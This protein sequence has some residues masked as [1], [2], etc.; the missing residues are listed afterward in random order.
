MHNNL[1]ETILHCARKELQDRKRSRELD[2]KLHQLRL[3]ARMFS[4]ELSTGKPRMR[5]F[6][7]SFRIGTCP[8]RVT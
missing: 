4:G 7:V 1:L 2:E 8:V 6:A 3:P 5:K